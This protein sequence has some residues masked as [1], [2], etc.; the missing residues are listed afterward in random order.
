MAHGMHKRML[1]DDTGVWHAQTS[2]EFEVLSDYI[3]AMK[4]DRTLRAP[5]RPYDSVVVQLAVSTF[6][7]YKPMPVSE[8]PVERDRAAAHKPRQATPPPAYTSPARYW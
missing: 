4:A 1:V 8:L 2:E 7:P 5:N 3:H 6:V